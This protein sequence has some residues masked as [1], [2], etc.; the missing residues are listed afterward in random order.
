MS[1]RSLW[2]L[3]VLCATLALTALAPTL[4]FA[5]ATDSTVVAP[6]PPATWHDVA[7]ILI[8]LALGLVTPVFMRGLE[9]LSSWLAAQ[10][11][12]TK[13]LVV[14]VIPSIVSLACATLARHYPWFPWDPSALN[15]MIATSIA[16]AVHAGDTAKATKDGA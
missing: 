8:T 2:R 9:S 15:A 5:Q 11:A 4:V 13:R 1:L 10:P 3:T 7:N 6:T 16:F 12:V 14:S